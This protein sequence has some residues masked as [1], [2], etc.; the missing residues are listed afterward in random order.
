MKVRD[1]VSQPHRYLLLRFALIIV[2]VSVVDCI[3][4]AYEKKP[5]PWA[6][7]IPLFSTPLVGI[8]VNGPVIRA[9]KTE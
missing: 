8:F 1:I 4:V 3:F 7:I 5:L 6:A 9:S 2:L